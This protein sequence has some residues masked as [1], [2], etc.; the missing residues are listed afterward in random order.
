MSIRL[1]LKRNSARSLPREGVCKF[2][3]R[4]IEKYIVA[5]GPILFTCLASNTILGTLLLFARHSKFNLT[6][7]HYREQ[8]RRTAL[9][10]DGF[11]FRAQQLFWILHIVAEEDVEIAA[12][13][14]FSDMDSDND[15][16]YFTQG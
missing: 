10:D 12:R 1:L 13:A 8:G 9:G 7:F 6:S 5:S 3:K 15:V 2:P 11:G 16:E 4:N 14:L